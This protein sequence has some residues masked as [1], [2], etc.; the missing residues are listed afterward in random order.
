MLKGWLG[1]SKEMLAEGN[2]CLNLLRKQTA[3]CENSTE[4]SRRLIGIVGNVRQKEEVIRQETINDDSKAKKFRDLVAGV[5]KALADGR[6]A[7]IDMSWFVEEAKQAGIACFIIR[8]NLEDV[9][10]KLGYV[11]EYYAGEVKKHGEL[12]TGERQQIA[13]EGL[14]LNED[15]RHVVDELS[16]A[17]KR[18]RNPWNDARNRVKEALETMEAVI[19]Q[20]NATA[21]GMQEPG[22]KPEVKRVKEEVKRIARTEKRTLEGTRGLSEVKPRTDEEWAKIGKGETIA[23][24]GAEISE[25]VVAEIKRKLE[26][27]KQAVIRRC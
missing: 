16:F 1:Q 24:I 12:G 11:S 18:S 20:I 23:N 13:E 19:K 6:E 7:V 9:L 22:G 10:K 25:H 15:L 3:L 26:E 5:E 2:G 4:L 21:E 27:E 17:I 14:K 8:D